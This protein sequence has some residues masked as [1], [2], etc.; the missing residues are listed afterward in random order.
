MD[1]SLDIAIVGGGVIGLTAAYYLSREGLRVGLLDRQRFG[2]EASWAGAGILPPGNMETAVSPIDRLRALSVSRF[3]RLSEELREITGIDNGFIRSGGLEFPDCDSEADEW[4][5]VG[6]NVEELS[7]VEARRLEPGLASGLGRAL[8]L[9]GL[10]QLRNPRHLKALHAAC[11]ASHRVQVIPDNPV[12]RLIRKNG[13]IESL[14]TPSGVVHADRFLI[15]AGA[16]SAPLLEPLGLRLD[17]RP[18]RGQIV[19]LQCPAP[20]FQRVLLQGSRYLV[21]RDD[22]RVLVGSTMEYVGY[23]NHT[24]AAGVRELLQFAC[25]L[26]PALSQAPVERAWAGLR[27]GSPDDLPYIGV[28]PGF[29]NLFVAS[30]H[31]RAGIQLSPGTAILL[32]EL[33]LGQPLSVAA[34]A[35][36]VD[37]CK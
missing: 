33:I 3:P 21:P 8:F 25:A 26:A 23:E 14:E 19:L 20:P 11:R 32:K 4:R 31:F 35:F 5:G 37:R 10:A 17:I 12:H 29:D 16:W 13:H 28:V 2:Q 30:G 27:P 24:T 36:R 9:P 18:V 7:E 34:D 22:G 1:R 6:V 15:A